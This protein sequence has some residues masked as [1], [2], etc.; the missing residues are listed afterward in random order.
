MTIEVRMSKGEESHSPLKG[1][2]REVPG[3]EPPLTTSH[4][5]NLHKL[6]VLSVHGVR[7]PILV[8]DPCHVRLGTPPQTIL[9]QVKSIG[10]KIQQIATTTPATTSNQHDHMPRLVAEAGS[11][12]NNARVGQ[13]S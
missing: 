1:A 11:I 6:T 8:H 9:L 12:L 13:L 3:E 4:A 2:T 10:I 5:K 7:T